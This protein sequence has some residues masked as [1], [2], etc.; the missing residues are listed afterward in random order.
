VE[1]VVESILP[2]TFFVTE[3]KTG[4]TADTEKPEFN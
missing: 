3:E 2:H 1:V 4:S